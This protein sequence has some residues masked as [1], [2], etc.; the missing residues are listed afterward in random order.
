MNATGVGVE[1]SLPLEREGMLKEERLHKSGK[2]R[3]NWWRNTGYVCREYESRSQPCNRE[4]EV[5]YMRGCGWLPDDW[6]P[7]G[8]RMSQLEGTSVRE[9]CTLRCGVSDGIKTSSVCEV[10][11]DLSMALRE[12]SDTI[13]IFFS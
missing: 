6:H 12:S 9:I 3:L 5:D 8:Y 10:N 13:S 11:P 1:S 2:T 4:L 7:R